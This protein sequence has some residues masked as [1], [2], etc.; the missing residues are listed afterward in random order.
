MFTGLVA[1]TGK[2]I[3]RTPRAGDLRLRFDVTDCL[4]GPLA[5]GES[6][7]VNGV[8]LTVAEID[9]LQFG[10]DVSRETLALTTLGQLESGATI[11]I[12][13]SIKVGQPLGGHMVSGH[14]DG[15]GEVVSVTRDA[16]SWRI[17]IA[18]PAELMRYIAVKGSIC[19]DGVSLTVNA[20]DNNVFAVNIV[21]HTAAVTTLGRL[22]AGTHVNLE[23]DIIARYLERLLVG[24]DKPVAGLNE[25]MLR[26]LG[27]GKDR[28]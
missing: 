27:Y 17:Q 3:G 6:I 24:G 21:P 28:S 20:V 18:A 5:I 7:A 4:E 8:C 26:N 13:Q 19:L 15:L 25:T 14:V 23:V 1:G 9:A 16:R 11:N 22:H 10:A 2:L 12:E